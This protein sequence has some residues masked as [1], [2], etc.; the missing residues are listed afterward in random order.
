MFVPMRYL[1]ISHPEKKVYDIILPIIFVITGLGIYN[2]LPV[3]PPLLGD[4]GV[5]KDFKDVLTL[6]IAFFVAALAAIA[7]FQ[8]PGLDE[9]MKGSN[10]PSI[11]V[12]QYSRKWWKPLT[13]REFLCHLFGYLSFLS[14]ILFVTITIVKISSPSLKQVVEPH[15]YILIKN[16]FIALFSGGIGHLLVTTM[17]AL[18]YLTD[19]IHRE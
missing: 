9:V 13:R 12:Y 16:I 5:L 15:S 8:R 19:R 14:L 3:K 18:Y 10:P 17:L 6:L 7:T 11:P 4:N 2:A 1:R